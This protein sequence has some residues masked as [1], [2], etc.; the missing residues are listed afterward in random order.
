MGYFKEEDFR[1]HGESYSF[2]DDEGIKF[3]C[4]T[5]PYGFV[6]PDAKYGFKNLKIQMNLEMKQE[7]IL[8]TTGYFMDRSMKKLN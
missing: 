2:L 3:E 6:A 8:M 7:N 5:K 4:M 1:D